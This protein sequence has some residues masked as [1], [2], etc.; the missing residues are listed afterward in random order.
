VRAQLRRSVARAFERVDVLAWPA[1]PAPAPPIES[2]QVELPSGVQP[3]D[4]A[5]TRLGGM[6]NLTGVPAA[7]VPVGLTSGNLPAGL[8]LLAPWRQD[9]RLLDLAELLEQ[10][11]GRRHVEAAPPLAEPGYLYR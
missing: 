2:P 5:N 7:S 8:Q 11:T 1:T 3:A 10:Q 6:A 4:F 9:E